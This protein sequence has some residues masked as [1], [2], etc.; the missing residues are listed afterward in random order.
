VW[1]VACIVRT[2]LTPNLPVSVGRVFPRATSRRRHG[3][4]SEGRLDVPHAQ[5]ARCTGCETVC[6]NPQGP[7]PTGQAKRIA[8]TPHPAWLDLWQLRDW[9]ATKAA[10]GIVIGN[11][12]TEC[13]M[14]RGWPA[15]A[16]TAGRSEQPTTLSSFS[17]LTSADKAL[18]PCSSFKLTM[19][20][21]VSAEKSA[22]LGGPRSCCCCQCSTWMFERRPHQ[23]DP[24][25]SS[26]RPKAWPGCPT[27]H[28]KCSV[29]C[30]L[31]SQKP[32][33]LAQKQCGATLP[34]SSSSRT[35]GSRECR[36]KPS[37]RALGISA[38]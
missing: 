1:R 30:H 27:R 2:R 36:I 6:G 21:C 34:A 13:R 29:V 35:P 23:D 20:D 19:L 26:T 24:K 7:E 28:T 37:P 22:K 18:R 38:C 4:G 3:N 15:W 8:L 9:K 5:S 17:K 14:D 10:A 31:M 33:L 32:T 16:G 12:H 11:M 25:V